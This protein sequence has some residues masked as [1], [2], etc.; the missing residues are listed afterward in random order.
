MAGTDIAYRRDIDGLRALAVGAVIL[1]HG[2]PGAVRGG[3]VGVDVFFV[4]SGFLISAN[5]LRRME[6]GRFGFVDFYRRRVRRIFPA[7]LVVLAACLAYGFVIL[8]PGE[9][10]LLGRDALGGAGFVA[11]LLLWHEAGYFDRA[12]TQKPL[13]HLWSLGVEEQFYIVWPLAL[14][15]LYRRGREGRQRLLLGGMVLGGLA[16]LGFSAA[17]A[18]AAPTEDF[19]SPL[20]RLW[21]L[22][23]GAILAVLSLRADGV[24]GA[25]PAWRERRIGGLRAA[26]LVSAAG[27][28]SILLAAL[29]FGRH[30][31][32]PGWLAALPVAGALALIAAGPAALVNRRLLARRPAVFVGLISYPLYLWHWPLLSFAS[33][34][35]QGRPLKP[36]PVL[37]LI[38]LALLLAWATWRFVERP[39]RFGPRP[40][41]SALQLAGLMAALALAGTAVWRG[42]GFPGRF[43]PLPAL[44]VANINAAIGD[45]V[46]RPTPGMRV[47]RDHGIVVARIGHGGG[48]AVLFIG[49]SVL[50]QYGPRVQALLDQGRLARTVYFVAGPSCAPVEGMRRRGSFAFCNRL[51]AVARAL[52]A[53]QRIGAVVIGASWS[54]YAGAD[55][56]VLRHGR[57]PRLDTPAGQAAFYA[58]LGDEMRRLAAQGHR[59]YLVLMPVAD[60]LFDPHHMMSRSLTGFHLDP[61]AL[62]GVPVAALRAARAP[63]DARLRAAAATA[64]AR[65]L[66]PLGDVCGTGPV[67]AAFYGDGQPK[68]V[69]GLHLRP[70][71]VA[72]RIHLLDRLLTGTAGG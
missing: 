33:I 18:R 46:F 53:R 57:R 39:F 72:A 17:I 49:D 25:M 54:G 59:V 22:D 58:N 68:F 3:F 55:M 43:P 67:C 11:N 14:W 26:D 4:I 34:L 27:L 5:I 20:T 16:S 32:F 8:L 45:G 56:R 7:L 28:G 70:G 47:R 40:S 35:S 6:A 15:L 13:L 71:F 50:F 52:M 24:A 1:Y 61:R 37:G 42:G 62:R 36:L 51:G 29:A 31:A 2:F 12:A 48:R 30:M 9:L 23:A 64:G 60:T 63:I 19:Y 38:L 69:D 66:D 21:E 41:R 65:V 44:N 10:A